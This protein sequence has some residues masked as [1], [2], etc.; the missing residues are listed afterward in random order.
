MLTKDRLIV[1]AVV[2]CASALAALSG[3]GPADCSAPS[4]K[5]GK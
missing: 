5:V 1:V 3:Y 2:A 4:C